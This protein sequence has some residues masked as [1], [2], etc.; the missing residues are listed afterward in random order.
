M[1][2]AHHIILCLAVDEEMRETVIFSV[3]QVNIHYIKV[4]KAF[5][6]LTLNGIDMTFLYSSCVVMVLILSGSLKREL[7]L[8]EGRGP[9][10]ELKFCLWYRILF[11][12]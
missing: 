12:G 8:S 6:S 10:V 9:F 1:T 2:N 7:S 3:A 5:G 4:F 11:S